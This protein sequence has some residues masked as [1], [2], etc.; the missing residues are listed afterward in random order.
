MT[1]KTKKEAGLNAFTE[2]INIDVNK[3]KI[4]I[5][6]EASKYFK[7]RL[8]SILNPTVRNM[9]RVNIFFVLKEVTFAI[10]NNKDDK[11][12][13]VRTK[14][15]ENF[16]IVSRDFYNYMLECLRFLLKEQDNMILDCY[17][18]GQITKEEMVSY[19]KIAQNKREMF[20]REE[21]EII[22]AIEIINGVIENTKQSS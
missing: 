20:Y 21:Q 15:I 18:E 10:N 1:C 5:F 16:L 4:N 8:D 22:S 12:I 6:C 7:S 3:E 19:I 9:V 2:L 14:T 17:N 11:A 13:A